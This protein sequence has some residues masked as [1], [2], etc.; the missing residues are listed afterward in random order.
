MR[1]VE[2]NTVNYSS[3]GK[4]MLDIADTLRSQGHI[5]YCY[6]APNIG[7]LKRDGTR[8]IG[9]E[10][11]R[12]AAIAFCKLTGRE[13]LALKMSTKAFLED[14]DQIQPDVIHLH[15]IHGWFVN[16]P[17]LFEYIKVHNTRVV[18]TLHDCWPFTGHCTYFDAVGCNKWKEEGGCNNCPQ[19]D[20]FPESL[21]DYSNH[22]F[23]VK[24][25]TFCGVQN[26]TLVT[27]SKWLASHVKESFLKEYKIKVINNGIDLKIFHEYQDCSAVQQKYGIDKKKYTLLGVA[28][29]WET[30]KGLDVFLQLRERL[31]QDFQIVLVGTS[32]AIE[33]QLPEGIIAIRRTAD[34]NELAQLYSCA[35]L[36]INPTYEDNFPTVNLEALA[37]GTA[38]VTFDTG[39]SAESIDPVCGTVVKKGDVDGMVK[40]IMYY[41]TSLPYSHSDCTGR[42][43]LYNKTKMARN[44]LKILEQKTK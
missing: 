13:D 37:C 38:V 4:I 22:M 29:Q 40:A 5:V 10:L 3:T 8:F 31:G 18:W 28:F 17:L 43:E 7:T 24:K 25:E 6:C 9:D 23:K 27:P 44:Y 19:K 21:V 20:V 1:I 16:A 32:A 33:K 14:L 34:Q 11:S 39:G 12:N 30:R 35:D 42:A 41:Y 36:F 26:M 15:C 2:I